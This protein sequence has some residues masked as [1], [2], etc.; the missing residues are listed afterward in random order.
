MAGLVAAPAVWSVHA[1]A[2]PAERVRRIGILV[3][4]PTDEPEYIGLLKAFR[5]RLAELGWTEGRNLRVELRWGGGVRRTFKQAPR[6]WW[7]L[8]RTSL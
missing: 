6:S 8:G 2:Q 4:A 3:S 5:E 1:F 7:V